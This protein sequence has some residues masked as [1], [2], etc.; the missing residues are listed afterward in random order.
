M[1]LPKA[2]QKP[3]MIYVWGS[4][5]KAHVIITELTTEDGRKVSLAVRIRE[6]E[7]KNEVTD[8]SS[9]F[10]KE[11]A[12]MLREMTNGKSDFGKDNLRYVDKEKALEWLSMAPPEGASATTQELN[13]VAK[14]IQEYENPK[15]SEEKVGKYLDYTAKM[16][17][18][19]DILA[20]VDDYMS[21]NE[22]AGFK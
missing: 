5:V 22:V 8:I 13:S 12:R 2:L 6:N 15:V 3:V 9:V 7:G 10:G 20:M 16:R 17:D 19:Q 1:N 11:S 4:N 21:R 18:Q 14:I